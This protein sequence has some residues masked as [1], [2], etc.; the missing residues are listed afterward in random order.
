[1]LNERT[2]ELTKRDERAVLEHNNIVV[3]GTLAFANTTELLGTIT[4]P[5]SFLDQLTVNARTNAG[6]VISFIDGLMFRVKQVVGTSSL[7]SSK[8]QW[9]SL[10]SI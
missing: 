6:T 1:M 10:K 8:T 5:Q 4:P 9:M 3:V 2:P 7:S